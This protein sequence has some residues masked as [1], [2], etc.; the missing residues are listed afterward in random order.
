MRAVPTPLKHGWLWFVKYS[1]GIEFG[2]GFTTK[3]WRQDA[4]RDRQVLS[5]F[6]HPI[7]GEEMGVVFKFASEAGS[8]GVSQKPLW[9]NRAC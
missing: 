2:L 6:S 8:N 9:L 7:G 5:L 1:K 4:A 3:G